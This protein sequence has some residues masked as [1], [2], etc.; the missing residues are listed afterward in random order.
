MTTYHINCGVVVRTTPGIPGSN[1]GWN[2]FPQLANNHYTDF[3]FTV[4]GTWVWLFWGYICI[5]W[6]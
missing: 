6:G 1:P 4:G 5:L 3:I 2:F